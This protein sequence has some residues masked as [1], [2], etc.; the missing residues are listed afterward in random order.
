MKK[1]LFAIASLCIIASASSCQKKGT[2]VVDTDKPALLKNTNDS[3][4]WAMGF[5]LAQNIA[6][7]GI[8]VDREIMFQA[9]CATLDQKQ[10]PMTQEQTFTLLQEIEA[11]AFSNKTANEERQLAETRS[12]EA[13]YF[14]KLTKENPN[15]KKSDK[16]FY[17][18]VL[19]EGTGRQC[20][21]GLI[22]VFDYKGSFING[23]LYD[24]TYG[25]RPPITHAVTEGMMPGLIEGLCIMKEGGHY[26]FYIPS[27]LA[28]GSTG[29][30]GIPPYTTVIYE[31]E[32]HEVRD[33]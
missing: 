6:S 30:D 2:Y 1:I 26:R 24:Q 21:Y 5:T 33:F 15:I 19:K 3:I 13:E 10:Q 17:Y 16:G 29:T 25:N 11:K 7:T 28:F 4:S 22:A 27:E 20:E 12:R 18:E 9:I 14:A 31:V 23:Q 32:L 8:N